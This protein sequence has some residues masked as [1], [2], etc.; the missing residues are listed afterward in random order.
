MGRRGGL[1]PDP[2]H[3]GVRG[4]LL[5]NHPPRSGYRPVRRGAD[6]R[7]FNYDHGYIWGGEL[8]VNYRDPHL[9]AYANLTLGQN[10]QR[11]VATGQFNFDP[12]EL[13]FINSHAIL[14]DHQPHAG[15]GMGATY[16]WRDY[17]VSVDGIYSSGLRGG[18]ADQEQSPN[19]FQL[20]VS[21]QAGFQ[22]PGIGRVVDRVTILNALDRT[23]LIHPAEGIG[24]F[25]S[26]FGPRFT[27]L[28]SLT[29]PF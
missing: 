20:N 16:S 5:R 10:G 3:H 4:R 14:L 26:A 1:S 24:I 9:T 29:I 18:F 12:D 15:A 7:P 6:L 23:D 17:A 8:A 27:V 13:A 25:Q 21:A 28:D 19:V 2:A 11:G 22:A